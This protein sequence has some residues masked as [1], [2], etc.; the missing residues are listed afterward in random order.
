M[1]L[2]TFAFE[3]LRSCISSVVGMF[4]SGFLRKNLISV[5]GN[6]LTR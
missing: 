6:T 4:N 3:T 1:Q 5:R 2:S